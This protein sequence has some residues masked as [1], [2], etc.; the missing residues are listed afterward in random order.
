MRTKGNTHK[1][2]ITATECGKTFQFTHAFLTELW[3]IRPKHL[4][5]LALEETR[6]SGN[7]SLLPR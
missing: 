1:G 7:R 4:V 3:K 5:R 6:S 2:E